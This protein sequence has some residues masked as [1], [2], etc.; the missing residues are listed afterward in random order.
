[1]LL[2]RYVYF[3]FV[4][5]VLKCVYAVSS[6]PP[7]APIQCFRSACDDSVN[8]DCCVPTPAEASSGGL[9]E[10]ARCKNGLFVHYTGDNCNRIGLY[11]GRDYVCC[12][13][14][15]EGGQCKATGQYCDSSIGGD[16]CTSKNT[17][18]ESP[19]CKDNLAVTMTGADCFFGAGNEFVCCD[20]PQGPISAASPTLTSSQVTFTLTLL[21]STLL[22]V[23]QF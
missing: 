15:P 20:G 9:D 7:E 10:P 6:P 1:M 14:H 12:D 11:A 18:A 21:L 19:R 8:Q 22:I 2:F 13:R 23:Y 5:V 16:C 17:G 3:L 4:F